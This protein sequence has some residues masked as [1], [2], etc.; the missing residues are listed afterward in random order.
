MY[1]AGRYTVSGAVSSL[2]P[3]T[4]PPVLELACL[5]GMAHLYVSL[6]ADGLLLLL[7][8]HIAPYLAPVNTMFI[9][10]SPGL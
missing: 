1:D 3:D 9:M 8:Y 6:H 4:L 2:S 10:S 7:Y 5:Y